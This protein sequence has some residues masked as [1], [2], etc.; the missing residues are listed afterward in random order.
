MGT[1]FVE[2]EKTFT[3]EQALRGSWF[4][5]I[6]WDTGELEKLPC[7]H[8]FYFG[9]K[10]S[11]YFLKYGGDGSM[12]YWV[13]WSEYGANDKSAKRYKLS[14]QIA[15]IGECNRVLVTLD[16]IDDKKIGDGKFIRNKYVAVFSIA[17][18]KSDGDGWGF[19]VIERI[20]NWKGK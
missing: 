16:K 17:D 10:T 14:K 15:E 1:K 3:I 2:V 6:R 5:T 8:N 12:F 13:N 18:F 4:V 9:F 20:A 7:V 19:R 11:R